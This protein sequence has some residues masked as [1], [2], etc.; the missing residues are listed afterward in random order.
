M[1]MTSAT[2]CKLRQHNVMCARRLCDVVAKSH[3]FLLAY[4]HH[5]QL[6][7]HTR[8]LKRLHSRLA[9]LLSGVSVRTDGSRACTPTSTTSS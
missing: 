6:S 8:L 1:V 3:G 9:Q 5:C 2:F 7:H 4:A